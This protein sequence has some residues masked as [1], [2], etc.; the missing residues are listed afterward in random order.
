M[1]HSTQR[2]ILLCGLPGSGKSTWLAQQGLAALSSD[3]V[4][5]WLADDATDQSINARVFG[6]LRFLVRQRLAIGRATTYVDATHLSPGERQPYLEIGKA[7]GCAVEAV[8]FDVPLDACQRRNLS[9]ERQVPPD[10]IERM[11]LRFTPPTTEEGFSAILV[12]RT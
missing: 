8:W 12:V 7:Y 11:A 3:A 9:R 4:R 10:A 1:P 5:Q 6:T 2:L